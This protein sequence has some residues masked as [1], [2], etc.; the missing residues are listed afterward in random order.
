MLSGL[1]AEGDIKNLIL[2]SSRKSMEKIPLV[3][4]VVKECHPNGL[5]DMSI[6]IKV[7]CQ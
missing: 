4:C 6:L 3:V 1:V 5:G 2:L 7:K